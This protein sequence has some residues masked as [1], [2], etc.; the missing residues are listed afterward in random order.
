MRNN[1]LGLLWTG[2]FVLGLAGL[3]QRLFFGHTGVHYGSYVPWGL[4][5]ALYI[6]F[7]GLSAGAFLL[8]SLV[9]VFGIHRLEK[10]GRLALFTAWISLLAALLSIWFDLGH[11]E[12]AWRVMLTPNFSSMMAWMVWLYSAYFLLLTVDI[13]LVMRPGPARGAIWVKRLATLGVPLAIAFHGGVGAL[14]AV[15]GAK[16]YWHSSIIPV[17]FLTGA[18]TSGGALLLAIVAFFWPEEDGEKPAIV[19]LLSR[20]VLGLLC[21]DL[22][23]EWAEIS[24]PLWAGFDYHTASLKLV[25]FGPYWWVFWVFHLAL[26]SLIPL[27]LLWRKPESRR[28][29]GA[30]G[31][32][33]VLTFMSVRL[34]IVIPGQVVP[35]LKGLEQ[36]YVEPHLSFR[37]FPSLSEWLL[38]LWIASLAVALFYLGWRYLPLRTERRV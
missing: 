15:V 21:F 29:L 10:I 4:W 6:Y 22:L 38:A 34:N 25:L 36:A 12:R 9:Y 32:L 20:L 2:A 19:S 16:P 11:M 18:L 8:S 24:V 37:Y 33:I 31:M 7:I 30:A 23:L 28:A 3:F 26:G 14:F 1:R 13:W 35:E 27:Y 17:L 5:V